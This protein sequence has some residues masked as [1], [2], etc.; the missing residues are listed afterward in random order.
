MSDFKK[1][2]SI[3]EIKALICQL[4]LEEKAAL[5]DGSDS[6]HTKAVE[7]LGIPSIMVADGPHGLRKRDPN[8]KSEDLLDS[9]P[10]ICFPTAVTTA[11]SWD[12]ALLYEMGEALGDECRKEK[13]S[14]ILGPGVNMKRSPLCGRNFEYFSEDPLLAGEMGAA[15][16]QGVQSKGVGTSLKHYAVNSQETRRMTIDAVVDQRTLR[17][18]YLTAFEIA[19]KKGKPWTVMSAYNKLNGEYCTENEWL[20]TEVLCEE[21]GFDGVVVSDWGAVNERANGLAA[22][23]DLEMHSSFGFGTEKII[24]AVFTG[25]MDYM[26]VV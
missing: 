24:K 14:V 11:C 23:N 18:F 6:W 1:P 25:R 22:G 16:I 9:V 13:V 19:V 20:Q 12:R 15:F 21:W 26:A 7:R 3:E 10:S 4:T 17:E 5:C 8:Y 2:Q